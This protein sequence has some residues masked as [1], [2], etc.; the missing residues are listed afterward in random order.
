MRR[1][2][3]KPKPREQLRQVQVG[4]PLG[5]FTRLSRRPL[6]GLLWAL[7]GP[8]K[9][10]EGHTE[11]LKDLARPHPY[12]LCL[13]ICFGP[14]FHSGIWDLP[15]WISTNVKGFLDR[16]F[17]FFLFRRF[18]EPNQGLKDP[19]TPKEHKVASCKPFLNRPLLK[20]LQKAFWRPLNAFQRPFEELLKV[21]GRPFEV[22]LKAF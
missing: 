21:V 2:V 18:R 15:L 5:A 3:H 4:R 6:K 16:F 19:K 11:H 8:S 17:R 20:D 14:G 1:H 9:K 7:L 12:Y 22:L 10:F 13:F